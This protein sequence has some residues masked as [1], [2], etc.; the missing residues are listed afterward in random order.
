VD[1]ILEAFKDKPSIYHSEATVIPHWSP[2]TDAISMPARHQF[3]SEQEYALTLAHELTHS[4]GHDSRLKRFKENNPFECQANRG[5]EELVAEIGA[6][7][8][9]SA[10]DV[11]IDMENA[12]AYCA[13]WLKALK[14]DP[15][16][17][18]KA[19]SLAQKA[20]D[21]MSGAVTAVVEEVNA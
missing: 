1:A 20:V 14:D 12:A 15:S 18:I 7:M 21:Y 3:E 6:C 8:V 17:I 16:M 2:M 4:T 9:L 11:A 19:S 13:D 10:H 5:L